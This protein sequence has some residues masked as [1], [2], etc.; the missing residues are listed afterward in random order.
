MNYV[1]TS[2]ELVVLSNVQL[3]KKQQNGMHTTLKV[4][5]TSSLFAEA[6]MRFY[7]MPILNSFH[8]KFMDL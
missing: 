4:E 7:I 8:Q 1:S 5:V 6:P 3:V 2:D